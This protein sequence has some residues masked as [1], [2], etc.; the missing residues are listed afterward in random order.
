MSRVA[1]SLLLSATTAAVVAGPAVAAPSWSP[2]QTFE[3]LHDPAK[4]D[5][6]RGSLRV[7]ADAQGNEVAAW[8]DA[9]PDGRWA[10]TVS[11]RPAAGTWRPATRFFIAP[12][13]YP[14][15]LQVQL[16]V[17]PTG[18]ALVHWIEATGTDGA[19]QSRFVTRTP[20]G[21]WS[22]PSTSEPTL[23]PN[24]DGTEYATGDI[25]PN[26]EVS[27]TWLRSTPGPTP[28][29]PTNAELGRL[30]RPADTTAFVTDPL[31]ASYWS[32]PK[33][34]GA[35]NAM[36]LDTEG[37]GGLT[38]RF[39]TPTGDWGPTQ[40]VAPPADEAAGLGPVGPTVRWEFAPD[41]SASAMWLRN[42]DGQPALQAARRTS[43]GSW[44]P[45]ATLDRFSEFPE[46][47]L[48]GYDLA[49]G[50]SGASI[51]WALWSLE[52]G[53]GRSQS[54]VFGVVAGPTGGWSA[55]AALAPVI[56]NTDASQG[57]GYGAVHTAV[58]PRSAIATWS[59]GAGVAAGA[60]FLSG[61]TGWSTP[62]RLP[63]ASKATNLGVTIAPND[64]A[65][66]IWGEA[67]RLRWSTAQFGGATPTPTP[68]PTP[69]SMRTVRVATGLTA[70]S[71]ARC[72]S[73]VQVA[74]N[75]KRVGSL[76][77]TGAGA[78]RCRV[79]GSL[80]VSS[81]LKAGSTV[82]VAITGSGLTPAFV[83]ATVS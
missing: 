8:L 37:D 5:Q 1:L 71:G 78:P 82:L 22:Q 49:V 35:G 14:E 62:F 47:I 81:S 18:W 6:L 44:G 58:G 4:L 77:V 13:R 68:T 16:D 48:T 83:V 23:P 53:T 3:W 63:T 24:S 60:E 20:A 38:S 55:K 36:V 30:L 21:T 27:L 12:T 74:V 61:Q 57:D 75:G 41:G 80:P 25:G 32:Q 66:V 59:T 79:S 40:R 15:Y 43:S 56:A 7:A 17:S 50:Q 70:L 76:A 46:T 9:A 34:D 65:S 28:E 39:R 54:Q 10:V 2:P 64:R 73:T 26:G 42:V 69:V 33:F 11:S 51:S 19:P 72:P 31:E 29:D 52:L 67:D 45:V